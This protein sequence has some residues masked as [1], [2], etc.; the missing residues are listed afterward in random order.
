MVYD[1]TVDGLHTFYVR[2]E[3]PHAEDLLVHNCKN[4]GDELLFP[5]TQADTLSKHVNPTR[6]QAERF[7]QENLAKGLP[8][9]NSV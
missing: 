4:L 5:D 8:P 9:I 6:A 3:G 2:A 1:L 7:A